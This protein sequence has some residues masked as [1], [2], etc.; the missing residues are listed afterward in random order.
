MGTE[1]N[2][3]YHIE[4]TTAAPASVLNKQWK[5]DVGLDGSTDITP[6]TA[7]D[8]AGTPHEYIPKPYILQLIAQGVSS[9][10]AIWTTVTTDE[11]YQVAIQSPI[12]IGRAH[13]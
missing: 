9:A 3:I 6:L 12:E 11:E 2:T 5:I 13:V 7:T 4:G 8:A 10:D 1:D